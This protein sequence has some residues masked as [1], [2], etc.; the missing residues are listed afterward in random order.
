PTFRCDDCG[1]GEWCLN[2]AADVHRYNP[3][4]NI[5]RFENRIWNAV[6]RKADIGI[7]IQLMHAPGDI[8]KTYGFKVLEDFHIVHH[9]GVHAMRVLPCSCQRSAGVDTYAQLMRSKLW[10]G[11]NEN[12]QTATTH[13]CLDQ[14]SRLS[15]LGRLSGYDYYRAVHAASDAASILGLPLTVDTLQNLRKPFMRCI[16]QFRHIF[17][18]KRAGRAHEDGGIEGTPEG[19]LAIPCPACPREGDNIPTDWRAHRF[20]WLFR[21]FLCTDANFRLSNRLTRSTDKTDPTYNNGRGYMV[22][23]PDFDDFLKSVEGN[24][25]HVEPVRKF[26]RRL[27][28]ISADILW[29]SDCNRFDAIALVNRKGGKGMRT[30]GIAGCFCARHEFILPLGLAPLYKGE[31]FTVMDYI[32]ARVHA[33]INVDEVVYSYD[34][35]CQW[36]KKLRRRLRSISPAF[37][38]IYDGATQMLAKIW[39]FV[40]P[41]MHIE[42]HNEKCNGRYNFSWTR[43]VGQTDGEGCERVWAGANPAATSMREMGPGSMKDTIDDLS[44]SWNFQKLCGL[45]E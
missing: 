7:E 8:C 30:T 1:S 12:P 14:F 22:R 18:F 24:E 15:L 25:D 42:G 9:N 45:R 23:I 16:R 26:V 37:A 20:P 38:G 17:Q 28:L 39:H 40:V 32:A 5:E 43:W 34:I 31:R 44:G 19:A 10:P 35:A 4:H 41:K 13:Q 3:L 33:S 27:Y 2:C 21:M 29:P 36:H 6:R 11:T